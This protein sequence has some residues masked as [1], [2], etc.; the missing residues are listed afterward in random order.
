[1]R[2]HFVSQFR[3]RGLLVHLLKAAFLFTTGVHLLLMTDGLFSRETPEST[4][5]SNLLSKAI[6]RFESTGP[7]PFWPEGR[8]GVEERREERLQET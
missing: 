1:M 3:L 7:E 4:Q 8:S 5:S 6:K 2:L